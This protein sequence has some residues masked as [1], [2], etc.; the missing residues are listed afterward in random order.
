[1]DTIGDSSMGGELHVL[2]S[3]FSRFRAGILPSSFSCYVVPLEVISEENELC[4]RVFV[5]V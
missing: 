5:F 2:E 3:H 1:M 4:T